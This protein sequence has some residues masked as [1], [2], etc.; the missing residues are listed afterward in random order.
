MHVMCMPLCVA[1]ECDDGGMY[2][3]TIYDALWTNVEGLTMYGC[4]IFITLGWNKL[5]FISFFLSLPAPIAFFNS[6]FYIV[7]MFILGIVIR[8][9]LSLKF[10]LPHTYNS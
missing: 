10:S 2:L 4:C 9:S 7:M 1:C 3:K 5:T 6:S 8:F